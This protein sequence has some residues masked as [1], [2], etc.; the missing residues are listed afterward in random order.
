MKI[1]FMLTGSIACYKS[2]A[3]I[4][5]LM[6]S[7]CEVQTV[8]TTSALQFLGAATLEGLTGRPVFQSLFEDGRRMDHIH[9]ARWADL[10]IVN[11]ATA[12]TVNE[13]GAG[14][15]NNVVS[16]L[17]LTNNFLKPV[18]ICPAMNAEMLKH[19]ATQNSLSLLKKWGARILE[20]SDGNLACGEYGQGRL[21]EPDQLVTE[22]LSFRQ[23]SSL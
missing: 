1:L 7:Q 8:A 15:G 12:N 11:P 20:G 16:S 3:A 23:R 22:V 13:L 14:L 4:S 5:K 2:A 9:L 21:I 19:P 10:L 18:W 17:V 6:Q